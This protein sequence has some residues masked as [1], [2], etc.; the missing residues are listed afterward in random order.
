MRAPALR[1]NLPAH[2][3]ETSSP[4]SVL[5]CCCWP[6]GHLF[7]RGQHKGVGHVD[8]HEGSA[9]EGTTQVGGARYCGLELPEC[10]QHLAVT[11][12]Y[13]G[14]EMRARSKHIATRWDSRCS[15]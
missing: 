10:L 9:D 3:Q 14:Q 11:R 7:D 1:G 12:G 5:K 2:P 4:I 8:T 6:P 13:I 15:G